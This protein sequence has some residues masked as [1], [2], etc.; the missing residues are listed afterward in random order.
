[1]IANVRRGATIERVEYHITVNRLPGSDAGVVAYN[2][3][4]GK[5]SVADGTSQH[6]NVHAAINGLRETNNS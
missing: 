2:W 5:L 4:S 1:M 6:M 3:R